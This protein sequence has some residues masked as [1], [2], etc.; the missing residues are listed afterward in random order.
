[1]WV[2]GTGSV[3]LQVWGD[4][5]WTKLVA[6]VQCIAGS[7]WT[8]YSTGPFLAGARTYV[9]I[10]ADDAFKNSGG[11][12]YLDDVFLGKVGGVNSV[13]NPGFESG[14]TNW[15]TNSGSVFKILQNP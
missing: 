4:S 13:R 2:K 15:S 9:W 6:Q 11:A 5:A 3:L 7:E 10:A 8:K 12:L 1:M 14:S